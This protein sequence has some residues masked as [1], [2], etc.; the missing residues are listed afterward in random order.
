QPVTSTITHVFPYTTLFRS[1][2][3]NGSFCH[4]FPYQ[5]DGFMQYCKSA[6]RKR[7]FFKKSC[8]NVLTYGNARCIIASERRRRSDV[9]QRPLPDRKSTRLNSSHVSISYAV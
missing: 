1:L 5:D 3:F 6:I 9:Q 4:L 8:K 7:K 2:A